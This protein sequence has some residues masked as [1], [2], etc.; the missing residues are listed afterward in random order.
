ML[1]NYQYHRFSIAHYKGKGI[2]SFL[3]T[4][5]FAHAIRLELLTRDSFESFSFVKSVLHENNPNDTS[6]ESPILFGR[7]NRLISTKEV[8]LCLIMSII[9]KSFF[10]FFYLS[11]IKCT[12]TST[13]L[14]ITWQA[15]EKNVFKSEIQGYRLTVWRILNETEIIKQKNLI[16]SSNHYF[17][18]NLGKTFCLSVN[19]VLIETVSSGLKLLPA[20]SPLISM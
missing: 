17:L 16:H 20:G 19:V 1:R 5:C 11:K 3:N 14:N 18:K 2:K 10:F 12:A 13:T 9:L 7:L 4:Y 8:K 6:E 15:V